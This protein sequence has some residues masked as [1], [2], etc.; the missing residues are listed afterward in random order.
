VVGALVLGISGAVIVVSV[1]ALFLSAGAEVATRR[2]HQDLR[3]HGVIGEAVVVR[4]QTIP[5]EREDSQDSYEVTVWAAA[6]SCTVTR[7]IET[8]AGH[9]VESTIPIRYDP[10]RPRDL[11]LLADRTDR[12]MVAVVVL[13]SVGLAAATVGLMWACRAWW[14][15][16][17]VA[18]MGL[19]REVAFEQWDRMIY[20]SEGRMEQRYL[21]LYDVA[22]DLRRA[23]LW[24][25]RVSQRAWRTVNWPALSNQTIEMWAAPE[26]DRFLMLRKSGLVVLPPSYRRRGTWEAELR[27]LGRTVSDTGERRS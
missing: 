8:L 16:R 11:E 25:V 5:R 19:D 7:P 24:C 22:D 21:V 17:R 9:P 1:A 6:C 2:W 18:R 13:S 14:R 15:R 27:I 10:K 4:T 20:T 3:R 23:P 12:P 26:R